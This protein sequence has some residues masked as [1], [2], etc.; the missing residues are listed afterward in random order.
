MSCNGGLICH[1]EREGRKCSKLVMS[2]TV[3]DVL[4]AFCVFCAMALCGV[5]NF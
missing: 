3:T 5:V 2:D 1:L 4:M